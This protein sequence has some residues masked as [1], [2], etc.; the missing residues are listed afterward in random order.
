M[1]ADDYPS[2]FKLMIFLNELMIEHSTFQHDN[3]VSIP[4]FIKFDFYHGN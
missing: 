4:M 2:E 3:N 1:Y